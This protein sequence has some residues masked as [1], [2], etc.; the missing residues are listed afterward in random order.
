MAKKLD[1]FEFRSF[2]TS[3][4]S[5]PWNDWADGNIWQLTKGEDFTAKP[6]TVAQQAR[7]WAK[8]NGFKVHVSAEKD[9]D[10][11]VLQFVRKDAE[12]PKP[13]ATVTTRKSRSKK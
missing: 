4:N 13:E 5:Y 9:G 8:T 10:K 11:V 12:T 1:K 6:Q 2:G 7:K 3:G